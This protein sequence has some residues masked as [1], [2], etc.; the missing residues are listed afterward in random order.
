MVGY[1]LKTMKAPDE[2]RTF[3]KGVLEVVKIDGSIVGRSV[4]QPGWRWSKHVKPIAKTEWCE[5]P[6]FLYC[7]SGRMHVIMSDGRE[8]EMGPGD[9]A[10]MSAGHDAYVA[11]DEAVV[12]IDWQGA[13]QYAL[14]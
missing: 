10:R 9:V 12:A 13:S 11:G 5:A 8:F 7:I 1:D 14:S 6:H 4:F 3:E 2:V